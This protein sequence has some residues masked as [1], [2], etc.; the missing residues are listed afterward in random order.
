M[1]IFQQMQ[2]Y[3]HK[4]I[5]LLKFHQWL[6]NTR[7]I[8]RRNKKLSNGLINMDT[9]NTNFFNSNALRYFFNRWKIYNHIFK[10]YLT[11]LMIMT[12]RLFLTIIKE[13]IFNRRLVI[14]KT[15]FLCRLRNLLP[16]RSSRNVI[17]MKR[18]FKGKSNE[19]R[20]SFM[21]ISKQNKMIS[22]LGLYEN[23]N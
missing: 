2:R 23:Y 11:P 22:L 5:R 13:A 14:Y 19:L 20:E 1:Y 4:N 17:A 10:M 15:F 7:Y 12:L 18:A 8:T 16:D 21:R 9:V 3:A 6:N